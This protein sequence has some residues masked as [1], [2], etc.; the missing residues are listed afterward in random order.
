M[1][2]VLIKIGAKDE[3]SA[4]LNKLKDDMT[5]A[6]EGMSE[7]FGKA[8]LAVLG[9][10][11]AVV[12]AGAAAFKMVSDA[13][14]L[15]DQFEK[16]SLRT[17]IATESLST[18]A[19]AAAQSGTSIE[20]VEGGLTRLA[21]NAADASEGTG[22]AA[23]AFSRL[24]V[25]ATDSSGQL[26][27]TEDLMYELADALNGVASDTEKAALAQD[28]FGRSGTNLLPLFASGSAGMQ[29]LQQRARD[30][31]QEFSGQA[32]KDSQAFGDAMDDLGLVFTG[33]RNTIGL[34]LMP[35]VT[36]LIQGFVESAIEVGHFIDRVGGLKQMFDDAIT[37]VN[38]F[39]TGW[40]TTIWRIFTDFEF[41]TEW[42]AGL[43]KILE[44]A[45]GIVEALGEFFLSYWEELGA[46]MWE[47]IARAWDLVWENIKFAAVGGLNY[48]GARFTDGINA[49][50]RTIN[51]IGSVL[52]LTI[53]EVDFTP[54]TV[55]APKTLEEQW[56][57]GTQHVEERIGNIRTAFGT[58]VDGVI[59]SSV[60]TVAAVGD[61]FALITSNAGPEFQAVA[62]KYRTEVGV[63]IAN[64]STAMGQ[65]AAA[66][67]A[68]PMTPAAVQIA[69]VFKAKGTEAAQEMVSNAA[70][71]FAKAI[72]TLETE[73]AAGGDKMGKAL[74]NTLGTTVATEG[75]GKLQAAYPPIGGAA[76]DMGDKGGKE[77]AG[78][79]VGVL[80]SQK[81]QSDM[82]GPLKAALT[83]GD[84]Q[85]ALT[86]AGTEWATGLG[87][88]MAGPLGG[89]IAGVLADKG[90][91]FIADIGRA[92]STAMDRIAEGGVGNVAAGIGGATLDV[93]GAVYG[94]TGGLVG[95][96]GGEPA[97]THEESMA[98][99]EAAAEESDVLFAKLR[100][101]ISEHRVSK[102]A[103][104]GLSRADYNRLINVYL[105]PNTTQP[106][107]AA[108]YKL[109]TGD[110]VKAAAKLLAGKGWVVEAA[111][112]FSGMVRSPT[113]FLAGERGPERVDVTPR[114]GHQGGSGG[115]V[116]VVFNLASA[117][118]REMVAMLREQL[119][120]I[121]RA[122]TD[123][124]R[125]G[126]RF[127][128]M[129]FDQRMIRTALQS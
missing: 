1:A 9:V 68:A 96:G 48:L 70:T 90:A 60:E 5:S 98:A 104:R 14:A 39:A 115:G 58:A 92:M 122:V 31:G 88:A 71:A 110:G 121:E 21:R 27:S 12:A 118:D 79:F 67:L 113:L 44:G 77:M 74:S 124:I 52:G 78:G 29:Q 19:Y 101:S 86:S 81:F 99:S 50:I 108:L 20:A 46:I 6:G 89:V 109:H 84:V 123:G 82:A 10:S 80:N 47:P 103:L 62:E 34:A 126:A 105:P 22:K 18:L 28:L 26:R 32:A 7:G 38:G 111:R 57:L 107:T 75:P 72:P 127:G 102:S 49:I 55:D 129:E 11:A 37:I 23:D 43:G 87:M 112:G 66:N 2:D 25:S 91:K 42:L 95:M 59:A 116:T 30:L 120:M 56:A 8:K 97:I 40:A 69:A 33:V 100:S 83:G 65:T 114:G 45:V 35:S 15:G 119:P 94:L 17:G 117:S 63:S 61:Q 3:A 85:G 106:E 13:A 76:Q 53:S 4:V 51:T 24:G 64:V 36:T 128:A 125:K 73:G 41:A 16:M 93:G 54:L